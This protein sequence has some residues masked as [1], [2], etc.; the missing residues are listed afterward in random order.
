MCNALEKQFKARRQIS[1]AFFQ[2][3]LGG[4]LGKVENDFIGHLYR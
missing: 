2:A 3:V 4:V 1:K